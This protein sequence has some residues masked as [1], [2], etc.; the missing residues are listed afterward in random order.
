M[1]YLFM[2]DV[3]GINLR[4]LE[5]TVVNPS[6]ISEVCRVNEL[7]Q[8][9]HYAISFVPQEIGVHRVSVRNRGVNIPGEYTT[10]SS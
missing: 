5:A 1:G 9:G 7:D 4:D 6:F 2:I 10:S 8:L 3:L